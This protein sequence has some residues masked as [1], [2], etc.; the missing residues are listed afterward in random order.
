LALVDWLHAGSARRRWCPGVCVRRK[1]V[2]GAR[3]HPL[4]L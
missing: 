3:G 1:S 4:R 2:G